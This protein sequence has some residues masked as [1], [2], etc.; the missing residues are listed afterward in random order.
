M[1]CE[2]V[3]QS[4]LS[5]LD[6]EVSFDQK[7]AIETHLCACNGCREDLGILVASL[8]IS[9]L[10]SAATEIRLPYLFRGSTK[11]GSTWRKPVPETLRS[12]P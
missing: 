7:E 2:N 10:L 4:L 12:L 5:Y 8:S 9:A 3:N 1:N 6:N 11:N